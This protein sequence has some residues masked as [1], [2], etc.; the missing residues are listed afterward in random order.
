MLVD[1]FRK[2][3]NVIVIIISGLVATLGYNFIPFKAYVIVAALTALLA[4]M[5]LTK[6]IKK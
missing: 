2:F 3:I 1:D 5:I 4:A 6:V